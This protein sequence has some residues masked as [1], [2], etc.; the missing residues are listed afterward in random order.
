[1]RSFSLSHIW[2]HTQ[3]S[4][5]QL[6]WRFNR[7]GVN[8]MRHTSNSRIIHLRFAL[9]H[10]SAIWISYYWIGNSVYVAELPHLI[11]EIHLQ[12]YCVHLC[13]INFLLQKQRQ[14]TISDLKL[15][16]RVMADVVKD[17]DDALKDGRM[18][19]FFSK[20]ENFFY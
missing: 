16:K 10:W 19:H 14:A 17:Q 12:K 18:P 13:Y 6:E 15:K 7:F 5:V 1:M 8:E 20:G 3:N 9:S 11:R 2:Q 4:V